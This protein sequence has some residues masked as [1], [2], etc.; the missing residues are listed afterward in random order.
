LAS[1][2]P[3]ILLEYTFCDMPLNPLGE[4]VLTHDGYLEVSSLPG[5]GL[6]INDSLVQQLKIT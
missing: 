4:L 2:R 3:E 1:L 6:T 5:L